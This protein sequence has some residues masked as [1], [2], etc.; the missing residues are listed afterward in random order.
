ME[1]KRINRN[2]CVSG[3]S[4]IAEMTVVDIYP[5][6]V[7]AASSI[8]FSG[9]VYVD[10]LPEGKKTIGTHSGTFHADE[11]LAVSMLRA[12]PEYRD[13]GICREE[14]LTGSNCTNSKHG[15]SE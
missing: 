9:E 11:A 7:K 6:Y 10:E 14:G 12:L 2:L 13:Y 5:P 8:G 4:R 1:S 3:R 15:H